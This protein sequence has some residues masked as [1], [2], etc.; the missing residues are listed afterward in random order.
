M[1][2]LLYLSASLLPDWPSQAHE[3]IQVGL[4]EAVTVC[5]QKAM[6][7]QQTQVKD[8]L[9]YSCAS[10]LSA[11]FTAKHSKRYI[12]QPKPAVRS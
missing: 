12:L 6:L 2:E 9:S 10:R 5:K 1:Q 7:L 4:L 11:C 3:C 8:V